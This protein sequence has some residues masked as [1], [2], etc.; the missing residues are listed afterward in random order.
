VFSVARS[1][2]AASETARMS[3]GGGAPSVSDGVGFAGTMCSA[4]G[5]KR[6]RV[7]K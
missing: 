1:R 2:N 3:T 6:Q 5:G 4:P 7:T